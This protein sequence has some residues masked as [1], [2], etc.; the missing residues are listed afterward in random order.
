MMKNKI[1]RLKL[2]YQK[3][4][5]KRKEIGNDYMRNY[6]LHGVRPFIVTPMWRGK[7]KKKKEKKEIPFKNKLSRDYCCAVPF[8]SNSV[9]RS[10]IKVELARLSSLLCCPPSIVQ[11][12]NVSINYEVF[13][14]VV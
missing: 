11:A 12:A 4:L 9:N 5:K 14:D 1:K 13:D 7:K 3:Y 2:T 6:R 8:E 10:I